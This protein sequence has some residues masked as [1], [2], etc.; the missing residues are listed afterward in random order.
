MI[1]SSNSDYN[2]NFP[3]RPLIPLIFIHIATMPASAPESMNTARMGIMSA[4]GP[5]RIMPRGR[6]AEEEAEKSA[7]TRPSISSSVLDCTRS[8]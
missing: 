6:A 3:V 5:K 7:M 8:R 2:R 4:R 1:Y